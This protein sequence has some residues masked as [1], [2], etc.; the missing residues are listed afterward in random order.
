[1]TFSHWKGIGKWALLVNE[2]WRTDLH[3]HKASTENHLITAVWLQLPASQSLFLSNNIE[4][5]IKH[6]MHSLKITSL[7][8]YTG[9]IHS[10]TSCYYYYYLY[11]S[12]PCILI[13]KARFQ[14]N[15]NINKV[16]HSIELFF[17][18]VTNFLFLYIDTYKWG[19]KESQFDI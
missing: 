5:T 12:C 18:L 11:L 19:N 9:M 3:T 14:N 10:Y 1:M 2:A 15:T 16:L 13:Y 17:L 7:N 6:T 8:T 4:S